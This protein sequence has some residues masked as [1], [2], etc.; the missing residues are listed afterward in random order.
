MENAENMEN[1]K[2]ILEKYGTKN[3]TYEGHQKRHKCLYTY[4][5]I[6]KDNR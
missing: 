5:Y 6:N 4:L 3:I 2:I 1:G